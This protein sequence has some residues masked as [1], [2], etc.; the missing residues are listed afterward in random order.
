MNL[1]AKEHG[2][3]LTEQEQEFNNYSAQKN[4][5]INEEQVSQ[6]LDMAYSELEGMSREDIIKHFVS[7][8]FNQFIE[9]Y[10][11]YL[12]YYKYKD[13]QEAFD[14]YV[15]RNGTQA[16]PYVEEYKCIKC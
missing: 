9:Y 13:I 11:E 14:N 4:A 10:K 6:Y 1:L 2:V 16:V 15:K 3:E 12:E 8:Q 7:L 5:E